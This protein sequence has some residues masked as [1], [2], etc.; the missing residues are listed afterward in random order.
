M[1]KKRRVPEV[2]WRLFSHRA[3]TLAEAITSLLPPP[4][5]R[6]QMRRC[7]R[8]SGATPDGFLLRPDD[9]PAYRELLT[10]SYVVVSEKASPRTDFSNESHW[11]QH[12]V[13]YMF[14]SSLLVFEGELMQ[15]L[16][17]RTAEIL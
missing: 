12:Q 3:R 6:C 7:L 2:L 5:C 14:M 13:R 15:V 4:D 10:Q 8:C 16:V 9:P 17:V 1:R 11:S